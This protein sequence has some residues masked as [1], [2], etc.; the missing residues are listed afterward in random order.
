MADFLSTTLASVVSI[1]SM[2]FVTRFL[3]M[4]LGPEGFGA[5]SLARRFIS[6]I[7]PVVILSM[8]VALPRYIAMTDDP[9]ARGRY[10]IPSIIMIGASMSILI[11][12]SFFRGEELSFVIFRGSDYVRLYHAGL[13]F[14]G[15]YCA[16]SV[17]YG[18]GGNG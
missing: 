14:L 7:A 1:I 5:Y 15:G 4:G 12:V 8:D 18:S 13:F 9:E 10:L 16:Y 6:N 3:A 11:G 17:T 2:V